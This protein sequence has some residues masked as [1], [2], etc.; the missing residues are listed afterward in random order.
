[1]ARQC[2]SLRGKVRVMMLRAWHG[3]TRSCRRGKP[4]GLAKNR[5]ITIIITSHHYCHQSSCHAHSSSVTHAAFHLFVRSVLPSFLPVMECTW[6]EARNA[7]H[8]LANSFNMGSASLAPFLFVPVSCFLSYTTARTF[9][10]SDKDAGS[11]TC[12]HNTRASRLA[13]RSKRAHTACGFRALSATGL[14]HGGSRVL[15]W[16]LR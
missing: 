8:V 4:F 1:M 11:C 3:A 12:G 13:R 10:F 6:R 7:C 16:W 5:K 14:C 9:S 2:Q 15:V